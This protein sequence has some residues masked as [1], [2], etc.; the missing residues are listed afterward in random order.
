MS[1]TGIAVTDGPVA[2]DTPAPTGAPI[3]PPT[4]EPITAPAAEVPE[5]LKD[6]G[7]DDPV[8]LVQN[9]RD[10]RS[11][12][13]RRITDMTPAQRKALYESIPEDVAAAREKD[14]REQL[15]GDEEFAKAILEK[16]G[17][18]APESY[19][20]A[21]GTVPEGVSV[22]QDHP[23]F[24]EFN[25]KAKAWGLT[26]EQYN[27]LLAIGV[28]LSMPPDP[29]SLEERVKEMGPGFVERARTLRTQLFNAIPAE[30]HEA[31]HSLWGNIITPAQYNA[32]EALVK[33][34][35]REAPQ[36]SAA[37]VAEPALSQAQLEAM[38]RDPRYYDPQ[39]R[40][41]SFVESIKRGYAKLAGA[42]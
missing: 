38:Q 28:K 13:G 12:I 37:P 30:H 26:N 21:K 7:F 16:Y 1:E 22:D 31:M 11:M 33:A 24:Q 32:F 2:G 6:T 27:E 14:L 39:R 15:S 25:E 20:I 18:K 35:V 40:D 41:P 23:A 5:W 42:I 29:G 36:P 4:A 10:Q 17:P 8:K 34:G 3:V 9:W 19:E